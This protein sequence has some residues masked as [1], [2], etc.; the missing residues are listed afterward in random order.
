MREKNRQEVQAIIAETN[1]KKGV[2][3]VLMRRLEQYDDL[4]ATMLIAEA[5][6]D[7]QWHWFTRMAHWNHNR[8][9]G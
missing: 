9:E 8:R 7:P 5:S 3:T 4:I 6:N 2:V 1:A